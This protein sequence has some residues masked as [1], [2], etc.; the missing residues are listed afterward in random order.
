MLLIL[1]STV[2]TVYILIF[3][4]TGSESSTLQKI[5]E[6]QTNKRNLTNDKYGRGN[7][8]ISQHWLQ[9]KRRAAFIWKKNHLKK[10]KSKSKSRLQ[11]C[12]GTDFKL[13]DF[14]LPTIKHQI[15][16]NSFPSLPW[17]THNLLPTIRNL[18]KGALTRVSLFLFRSNPPTRLPK[19]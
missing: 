16:H 5:A 9:L 14:I 4:N 12:F 8:H 13:E 11:L 17:A 18:S 19:L 15:K 7:N 6:K 1:V 10:I 3:R 2:S